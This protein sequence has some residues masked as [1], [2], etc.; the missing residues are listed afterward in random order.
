VPHCE[1]L[2]KVKTMY[3]ATSIFANELLSYFGRNTAI[4]VDHKYGS[5]ECAV[6]STRTKNVIATVKKEWDGYY[7]LDSPAVASSE[8]E[9]I[10]LMIM[11]SKKFPKNR[12]MNRS[13]SPIRLTPK[14]EADAEITRAT[15]LW[16]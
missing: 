15:M 4:E 6:I 13:W 5:N 1:P 16:S 9:S 7:F 8:L 3:D 14:A 10:A 11:Q 12:K 2:R